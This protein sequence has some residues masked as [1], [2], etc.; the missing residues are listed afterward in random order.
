M[1]APSSG[2]QHISIE[3]IH[4][5]C[6]KIICVQFIQKFFSTNR[7]NYQSIMKIQYSVRFYAERLP[8]CKELKISA[9]ALD[10]IPSWRSIWLA[11]CKVI[12]TFSLPPLIL[13]ARQWNEVALFRLSKSR[14]PRKKMLFRFDARCRSSVVPMQCFI[15]DHRSERNGDIYVWFEQKLRILV[16]SDTGEP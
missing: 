11:S 1:F 3:S 12:C 6:S 10:P 2:H 14:V 16:F 8:L 9:S 5:L 13:S 7:L 4:F 15:L